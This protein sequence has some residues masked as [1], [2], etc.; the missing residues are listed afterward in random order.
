MPSTYYT[1]P[2][3]GSIDLDVEIPCVHHW[4]QLGGSVTPVVDA[5][6]ISPSDL[7]ADWVT[8]CNDC[9]WTGTI[10]Q[11]AKGAELPATLQA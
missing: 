5:D 10:G 3:C 11:L 9:D 2:Q 4:D 8:V 7:L 1:C 6:P